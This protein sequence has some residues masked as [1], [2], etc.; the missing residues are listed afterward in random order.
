MR[1]S[2]ESVAVQAQPLIAV[3]D[4]RASSRWYTRLLAADSLPAHSHRDV[5]DR[6]YSCGRLLLQLHVWDEEDHPNL[7]D[8]S[9]APCGHG[10][11]LWFEVENFD[12]TVERA[13]ELAAEVIEEPHV[14]PAPRHRELWLRDPDGYVVVIASRDG[15]C[16]P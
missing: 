12:L 5:Y 1:V 13:R 6:I 8:A 9:A 10:V 4:V 11:L 3:R 7:T 16:G 15:E 14:N 2:S